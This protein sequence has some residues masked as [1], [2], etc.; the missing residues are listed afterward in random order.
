MLVLRSLA[1]QFF[2]LAGAG[3][4]A[5]HSQPVGQIIQAASPDTHPVE[6][7]ASPVA[8]PGFNHLARNRPQAV[9]ENSDNAAFGGTCV[10]VTLGGHGKMGLTAL[11]GRCV[12]DS[13]LWWETSLNL[14][15]CIGNMGGNMVYQERSSGAFDASCR[16]CTL[17]DV[18]DGSNMLL[19]CNC[20]DDTR[21]PRYTALEM[22]SGVSNPLAVKPVDGRLICGSRMGIKSPAFAVS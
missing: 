15:S 19:K 9:I 21:F 14:N 20:L 1:V 2:T 4:A 18:H 22:G 16:P 12:D 17:D 8:L 13:G 6:A 7:Q 3:I 5:P 11:E 10:Q